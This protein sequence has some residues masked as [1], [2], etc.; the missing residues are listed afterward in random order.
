MDTCFRFE[1]TVTLME[2]SIFNYTVKREFQFGTCNLWLTSW[3]QLPFWLIY[4]IFYELDALPCQEPVHF[5][6]QLDQAEAWHFFH[7]TSFHIVPYFL[8]IHPSIL[9]GINIRQNMLPRMMWIHLSQKFSNSLAHFNL[10]VNSTRTKK[11][12]PNTS[13]GLC[14]QILNKHLCFF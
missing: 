9:C 10:T 1:S 6:F 3:M 14:S 8:S 2:Y 4:I 11:S 7:S 13:I 5:P 12:S